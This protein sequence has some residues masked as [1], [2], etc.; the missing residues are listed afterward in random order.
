MPKPSTGTLPRFASDGGAHVVEPSSGKKDS[1]WTVSERPPAGIWNWLCLQV[2]T[3]LA[4]IDSVLPDDVVAGQTQMRLEQTKLA[5]LNTTR[6]SAAGGYTDDWAA[7]AYGVAGATDACTWVIVG[8]N[9]QIQ[10]SVNE[11][12]TWV[13]ATGTTGAGNFTGVAFGGGVFVAV[14]RDG[15]GGSANP[16]IYSS[17]NGSAWTARTPGGSPIAGEWLNAVTYGGGTFCA[18]GQNGHIQTSVNGTAWSQRAAASATDDLTAVAYRGGVFYAVGNNGSGRGVAEYSTGG[19]T[20]SRTLLPATVLNANAIAAGAN[21]VVAVGNLVADADTS[22]VYTS[23]DGVTWTLDTTFADF[24]VTGATY[25][26]GVY[27]LCTDGSGDATFGSSVALIAGDVGG[28]WTKVP[29]PN[30]NQT[31]WALGVS[32]TKLIV[33]GSGGA[34]ADSLHAPSLT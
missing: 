4:W 14:G 27:M 2:Y 23:T 5:L 20:W 16:I 19:T 13:A 3:W 34:V 24:Y 22:V 21:E 28:V 25:L 9:D 33:V 26:H 17:T 10:Y 15:S 1:G 12:L 32:D 30:S 7:V 31:L 11:G 18:V 8:E 6:R 29:G